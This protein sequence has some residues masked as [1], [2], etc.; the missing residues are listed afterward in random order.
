MRKKSS[1]AL[2]SAD[3]AAT[4]II[5]GRKRKRNRKRWAANIQEME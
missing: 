5:I 3:I 2:Q 4:I 1:K